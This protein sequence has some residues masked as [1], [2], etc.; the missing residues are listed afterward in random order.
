VVIKKRG[1]STYPAIFNLLRRVEKGDLD[2]VDDL[3]RGL[4]VQGKPVHFFLEK[5][6]F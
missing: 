3:E 4:F 6:F 5:S 1:I 2:A